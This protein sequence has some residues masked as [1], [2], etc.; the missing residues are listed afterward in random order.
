VAVIGKI[1]EAGKRKRE[2]EIHITMLFRRYR[3]V[4]REQSLSEFHTA[5][6]AESK[7]RRAA[8]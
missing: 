4:V 3:N 6:N 8:V 5:I 7:R 1:R 2:S